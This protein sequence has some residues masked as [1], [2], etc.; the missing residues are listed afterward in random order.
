MATKKETVAPALPTCQRVLT[1]A[2]SANVPTILWGD[3][4]VAKSA[5][6]ESAFPS[7]GYHIETV[8]IGHSDPSEL[9]GFLAPINGEVVRIPPAWTKRAIAAD[10][11]VVFFDEFSQAAPATQGACL[12]MLRERWV[13]DVRLPETV[14]FVLAANRPETAAGGY[15]L[16]APAANRMLHL[17]WHGPTPSTW[18]DGMGAGFDSITPDWSAARPRTITAERSTTARALVGAF[19]RANPAALHQ[20]PA[21][22]ASCGGPWPSRR[23]WEMLAD[24]LAALPDDDVE[25]RLCVAEGTVGEGVGLEFVTFAANAD[26]PNAADVLANPTSYDWTDTRLDRHFVVLSAVLGL[27]RDVGTK[28]A[29]NAAW[30]VL[31][32]AADSGRFDVAA[33]H[34]AALVKAMQPG[35]FPP[36]SAIAHYRAP[37]D[38]AGLLDIATAA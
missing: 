16:A 36:K 13:G 24:V 17:E 11:T 22:P 7:W 15:D 28:D 9:N 19:I 32:A 38:A 31:A 18:A 27:T 2:V 8:V 10:K 1:A 29:W 26:L 35:W 5:F 25:A 33:P 23:S 4:G 20:L 6:V 37:L 21:D 12:R 14:A 30:S 34:A 3:P